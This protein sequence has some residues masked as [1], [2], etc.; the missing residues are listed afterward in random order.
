M[1]TAAVYLEQYLDSLDS[2]PDEMKEKFDKIRELDQKVMG[3]WSLISSHLH[4]ALQY[5]VTKPFKIW[6]IQMITKMQKRRNCLSSKI[7]NQDEKWTI[8]RKRRE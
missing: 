8:L 2:L 6:F 5:K 3:E 1:A 7:W 4:E